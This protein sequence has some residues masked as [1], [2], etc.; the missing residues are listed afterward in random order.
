VQEGTLVGAQNAK[1]LEE[2]LRQSVQAK[3]SGMEGLQAVGHG[4]ARRD[5]GLGVPLLKSLATCS[6]SQ[7][8]S[9]ETEGG[10]PEDSL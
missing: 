8:E 7:A 6:E 2:V 4:A 9:A 10:P 3:G 5:D 1:I